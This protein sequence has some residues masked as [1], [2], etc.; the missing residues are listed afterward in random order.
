[1]YSY[2]KDLYPDTLEKSQDIMIK[3]NLLNKPSRS[4]FGGRGDGGGRGRGRGSGRERGGY[5]NSQLSGYQ[6]AQRQVVAGTDG[7]AKAWIRCFG[8]Q[9]YGHY[10]D[11]CP[12]SNKEI[13]NAQQDSTQPPPEEEEIHMNEEIVE[14]WNCD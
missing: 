10:Q 12:E 14:D 6:Y 8:C 2:G 3:H 13:T 7:V 9:N 11:K 5:T 1:M 4:R